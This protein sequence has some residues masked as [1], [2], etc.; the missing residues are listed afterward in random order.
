M[1]LRWNTPL[2]ADGTADDF[3]R[4]VLGLASDGGRYRTAQTI[5]VD[6]GWTAR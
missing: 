3:A 2:L 5:V 4:G 1:W 6:G